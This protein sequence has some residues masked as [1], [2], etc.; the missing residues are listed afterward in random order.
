MVTSSRSP[1]QAALL[2]LL[3][4]VAGLVLLNL[5]SYQSYFRLDFTEDKRYTLSR[6]TTDILE[7]LEE[8]VTVNIYFSEELPPELLPVRQELQELLSEYETRSGGQL[9]YALENPNEAPENEQQAQQEGIQPVLVNVRKRD[10][11]KQMRVYMGAVLYAGTKKEVIPL[12]KHDRSAEHALTTALKK[13]TL[14]QKPRLALIEG[15]GEATEEQLKTLKERL[16]ELYEVEP[17]TLSDTIDIPSSYRALIWVAPSD[18]ITPASF[19][20]IDQYLSQGGRLFL[21]YSPIDADL[22]TLSLRPATDLGLRNW[23]RGLQLQLQTNQVLVDTQCGSVQV[24]QNL[25]GFVFNTQVRFPYFPIV[26]PSDAH[27]ISS[28]I[29]SVS[30]RFSSPISYTAQ[31]TTSTTAVPLLRSSARSGLRPLPEYIDINK[32]WGATDFISGPQ[33]L[34]LAL[35]GGTLPSAEA[36]MVFFSDH[37]F[38]I[39]ES[40]QQPVAENNLLLT[41]N[42]IDWLADDTGLIELRSKGV[43]FR[44]LDPIEDNTKTYLSYGNMFLPILLVLIYAFVHAQLRAHKRRKWMEQAHTGD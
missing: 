40:E 34:A 27:P 20:K 15:H 7:D 8:I 2:Q 21:A 28:D 24:A 31:D 35:E 36:K 9:V 1:R 12:L 39:D 25:G 42:A 3:L 32:S 19:S 5:I 33:T 18:P 41:L 37:A 17:F 44:P 30:L 23:L 29:E 22:Q 6:S 43:S 38:I 10:Q 4:L 13:L 16:T 11:V 14:D 26:K